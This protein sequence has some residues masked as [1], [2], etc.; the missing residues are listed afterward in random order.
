MSS[1][2][3]KR[4]QKLGSSRR[5]KNRNQE[6]EEKDNDDGYQDPGK[7]EPESECQFLTVSENQS[8]N[9]SS[10]LHPD[11]PVVVCTSPSSSVLEFSPQPQSKEFNV[12]LGQA[13]ITSKKRKMGSTRKGNRNFKF[14]EISEDE[15]EHRVQLTECTSE[16]EGNSKNAEYQN[17]EAALQSK[18]MDISSSEPNQLHEAEFSQVLMHDQSNLNC[19]I[20]DTLE[21]TEVQSA[22][23]IYEHEHMTEFSQDLKHDRS[24]LN[25]MVKDTLEG[26]HAE[27]IIQDEVTGV[28]SASLI[29]EH[30]H[31]TEDDK[32]S[33]VIWENVNSKASTED[34]KTVEHCLEHKDTSLQLTE[35]TIYKSE[36]TEVREDTDEYKEVSAAWDRTDNDSY[37]GLTETNLNQTMVPY[38][39][40]ISH[41]KMKDQELGT[42]SEQILSDEFQFQGDSEI[43]CYREEKNDLSEARCWTGKSSADEKKGN[44]KNEVDMHYNEEKYRDTG[45]EGEVEHDDMQSAN[46]NQ[47]LISKVS[48]TNMLDSVTESE[49]ISAK[50]L[51]GATESNKT[52]N[53]QHN[54][55]KEFTTALEMQS[56]EGDCSDQMP[57]KV[58]EDRSEFSD[59]ET[60]VAGEENNDIKEEIKVIS[61]ESFKTED[62]KRV[63]DEKDGMSTFMNELEMASVITNIQDHAI[64]GQASIVI[65]DHGIESP[66][67]IST[68]PCLDSVELIHETQ[69][70]LDMPVYNPIPDQKQNMYDECQVYPSNA[71]Q[72]ESTFPVVY[73]QESIQVQDNSASENVSFSRSKK[74]KIDSFQRNLNG[75]N[76]GGDQNAMEETIQVQSLE[77]STPVS[78]DETLNFTA[79]TCYHQSPNM[80]EPEAKKIDEN[81]IKAEHLV[82]TEVLKMQR[83]TEVA[84]SIIRNEETTCGGDKHNQPISLEDPRQNTYPDLKLEQSKISE[85][86][87]I[88][89]DR[90]NTDHTV[91]FAEP[92]DTA[93]VEQLLE[94]KILQATP[95]PIPS[96]NSNS[97]KMGSIHRTLREKKNE[98]DKEEDMYVEEKDTAFTKRSTLLGPDTAAS[99]EK[100]NDRKKEINA[101]HREKCTTEAEYT[102]QYMYSEISSQTVLSYQTTIKHS[103]SLTEHTDFQKDDKNSIENLES[104]NAEIQPQPQTRKK[105]K[106]GSTRRPSGR[107]QPPPEG[108]EGEWKELENA[109]EIEHQLITQDAA[110]SLINEP[111]NT[112]SEVTP[113]IHDSTV[114]TEQIEII[115]TDVETGTGGID[116]PPAI[117]SI[118]VDQINT[119][120]SHEVGTAGG[121]DAPPGIQVISDMQMNTENIHTIV[122]DQDQNITQEQLENL[123]NWES[124]QDQPESTNPLLQGQESQLSQVEVIKEN[125]NT[126]EQ[127]MDQ[128]STNAGV[129]K[130]HNNDTKEE[131][132]AG[133]TE[134]FTE[135]DITS[136]CS[137]QYVLCELTS[138]T[139][140]LGLATI[141]YPSPATEHLDFKED[142]ANSIENVESRNAEI[143]PQT[144]TRKKKKIGST[145]RP[146][147]R[148]QPPPEGE[149]GEWKELENA[150]EI[151]H[152]L[153]TQDATSNLI[154]EP[155]NTMS[156]VTPNIH[157]S[158]V[159]TEQIEI[160]TTDVETGTGGIDAQPSIL[161]VVVDQI[162]TVASH[163]VGNA[164]V[165]TDTI[166]QKEKSAVHEVKDSV[167]MHLDEQ[168]MAPVLTK[169][170]DDALIEHVSLTVRMHDNEIPDNE[171][172]SRANVHSTC[173]NVDNSNAEIKT[174]SQPK[175]KKKIGSTRRPRGRHQPPPEGEEGEWKELEN[176]EE[177]EHQLITQDATSNL[178]NEPQNTMSEVT[179]NIHDSTETTEQIEMITT[180]VETGTGGI[181]A[182][183]AILSIEVDQI[184][185]VVSHEVGTA[186]GIDAPPGIQVI[187]DMQMNTENIHTSVPDQ[188]QNITQEQLENLTNWKSEQDQPESTNPLLQGQESQLSQVE[189]I[190]ENENTQ[191]Q[192]KDQDSTN[193]GVIKAHNNDTK[194]EIKA[195]P[196]DHFTK[197][198][199]TS[200]CSQQY[201]LCELTSQT[202]DLGLATI[203]YPS[204]ATEHLD[205]TEDEANSIENVESR[206]AEIQPQTQTR[207]KKKIGSTRRPRGRHQPPP[208]GEEGE[209]KELEN[210]EEIEHQLITQDAASSLINEPQNTMSE[211]T[212][213]IHDST[214]TTE[215]I[216][217]I[218]TDVETGTG[219]IDAQPS[220]L[221]VE[222]DQIN[223]VASREV[224]NAEVLTDTIEQKEKSAVHEVKD[225]VVMHLNEQEMAPVVTKIQDDA[226]IEHVSLTVRMHDNEILDNEC[227]SRAN[228]HSTCEN[229]DNSNAEIETQSQTKTKKKIGSTRRPRG[230][231]QPPPE[232][233]E[234]EW[235]DLENAE[236]IEHQLITQVAASSLINEPQNTMSEVT[237]NIHDS[238]VTTEQIEIITTDVETGTGGID[239]PP[240]ILSIEV[241]QI[242]TVVSHEVATA[243]GIDAPPGIQVI[244]DMQM[245]TENIRTI[246]PDQDQNITQEQLENLTN[247]ESEQDQPESTNPLLQGQESQLSQ[248][249]VIKENENTQ[250]QKMDQDSTNAGVIKA[251]NNDTKE[252]IKAG[253][254]E[255]FTEEDITSAC[256]QQYVLCELTSQTSDLGLATI[257]YP[258]PATEHLDFKEDEANS[259]ENVKSRNAEIQPQTQ[260]RKKKKI[261][262]TRRPRGRHQPPPEGEEGEWKELENAEEIEHQLITQDATSNLINEP[263]NTMSEVTP[264][265]HDS[266]VTTEQIEIISTDV[267]TGTGGIDAQPSI[268]SVE[269]DQINT[270]ASH[271]VGNAEVLTDTIEQKEKSA[272]HEVKDS[273]VMHLDEQE[274][275]PVV[276]KIQDDALIEHVSLTVR[277]HD[278]EIPDNECTS[279]ANV[280]STCEN[281]DN[282][283]AEIETQSQ[284]KTKKKIGSTRRPRGRHQPPPEGEEGEWKDLENAEEIEHQLIT[285]VAASSLINEPQNTMSE[286]TPN[287]HDSTETTEQIEMITT[288][289][290]TGTGGIDAPPAILSIEVDQ[291]NTVVSHEVGTAG[292]IDAPP[293]IQVISDMQMNTENIHTSVPDQDQNITQ[294]QLENLTNWES[295]QDQ[296]ENT[297]PLL[298]GQESQLF[299]VEVIKENENTQEQKMDQDSTNAGVIKAH[300]NDTKEEIKA[301]PTEHFT[302]EDITSACSQQYV[303]CELTSQTSDLG[304]ATIEYPSPATE[305]PDFKEDEA[306]SIK[307]VESR[308]AEIQPQTQT[309]KKKK[310]GSTRRPRGRHQPPPE[311]EEGEWKELENAEEIEH[312]LITQDAASSLIN[313][314]QNTMSEVTPN[315]H[316]STVTTEQIEIISTDV[317]TGTGGID[318]Q[319]SILSV[320]VDQINTVASHEVGNA[321]VLT[322]TIEQK[323]K[324]AVHEVKDSVVMH[325]D[326]QEMAPVLTKI[327]DDVLIEHVS[328]TVR[329]H[330]NEILDNECA[331]RANVHSTCE[332]VDN[333]NAEIET[334]SQPKTKKKIGSTRRPRGRHQPPPEGEEGEWKD[335]ENAEE[336]EHQLITQVAAS[337]LINEPQNTMSEVTP[338][339]HDSTETT[340]QIEMITTDVETGTGGIDAPPAILSIE[341]DQINTVV[342]HE[343]GTA[344]GIDAPP[345]TQVISDMQMNTENIHTI[346]PDQDQNITQEQLENLTNWESE[347]DQPESTNPLLQGQE[348]Q[349]FQV[350]VI[351]ENENTQEQKM[352]QDSTNAGVIE[353]HNNDT[354]EEII[355]GPTEHFT[356]EDITSACS[357]QYVL[358]ELTSQTSDLGLATIEYPS[359]ATEHPDFKEDEANSIE[360]V[361]SR[362]AEIQPQTQTRKKKKIGSTR[363]P[364]GRHQPPPEGDEGE[365]KELENAEEIEHQLITQDAASSLINEPQNTM[366]EVTPNIHD[367]TV[368]TEQIEIITTDVETGTGGI[369]APPSILSVEVDQI[370]T[371]ASHEVGNAE[372]LTDTIE[373]KEK[374]AVHEV[375]DS[376]LMHLDEQEMAPVVTKIQDDALIEHV[377]LTV[378]MHD[379]EIPDNECASRANVH[380][381]CENVDNSNAEIKTQSQPKAKKKI[382]ST[383]RPRGRHQPPPEGEEGEWKDLENAEEIEHQLITQVAASSL[384][385]EPQ[386]TMSE[387]TP[388][389]HDSTETTEQIEMITTDVETGTGGIDAPPAILSIEV[390][391][392]NTVVSHEVGT[393]GGIDAPPGI[394]VI[395]DMQMNTENIHT[396]VPDQ[397][398]NITQEQLENLTNWESEQDQPES[399]N[400]LLQ[401]QESQLSQVEVIKENEN[402]Q[403]QKM[404]QDSTNAGV[405]KAHNNDTKEDIKTG[406]TE[407]FTEEDITSACSQQY[408][409]CELTSQTSD[410]GL[411][412]IEY[413]S[414]AT[415]HPDFKEDEANSI[416]NVESRNVEIQPQTQ[417][418][419]K[420]KIGS[421]RRPRGRHQPPPE[422]EEGEWKEL[423]NAEEI[424]HQL[425][426][427]VAASS[428]INE[429]QNTMSEVT[430]NIHDSTVTTEQIEI[431]TTEGQTGTGGIDAQ[432]SILSVE[433]D[434]INTVASH[435]VG[436]AEGLTDTI[437]QK[438]KSAVHEVKDSVVMHLDEQEMAPVVTKIQDD[439]LIEH[440]SL[441]VRMHDNEIPDNE[442]ASRANVHSTCENVESR[443]AEIQPQTQTRKKKKIGST[444]R[445]RGRHQPPPE[446]EEGEWKEL[447]N[448]EEIEHQLITQDAA[449]SLINEPQNTMSEVTPNI[450]DSTVTTEQIEIITTD[451]ETGTGGIDAQPSILSVEVDQINTVASHEVG[452]AEGLTDTI[453]QKEKSAVHEVKDS[454]LMHLD[455]QEMAPVVTKIQ[456]DAL[457]EHVSL[458]VRMHDNEIPDNECA[459]IANVHSTCENMD[460]SNAGIQTQRQHN[461]KKKF[462]STRRP[463]GGHQPP[464]DGEEEEWKDLENTEE[465][466][467]IDHAA[468]SNLL[469][470]LQNAISESLDTHC[471][472]N[473]NASQ[474]AYPI[475]LIPETQASLDMPVVSEQYH[476]MFEEPLENPKNNE[477]EKEQCDSTCPIVHMQELNL[478]P[479]YMAKQSSGDSNSGRRKKIGSTRRS[480]R[481]IK[482]KENIQEET[483]GESTPNSAKDNGQKGAYHLTAE[484]SLQSIQTHSDPINI[485]EHEAVEMGSICKNLEEGQ[486]KQEAWQ[487]S[488]D[489]SPRH[490]GDYDKKY[491]KLVSNEDI[492]NP[493]SSSCDK[494]ASIQEYKTKIHHK[495]DQ[496]EGSLLSEIELYL[497]KSFENTLYA[498]ALNPNISEFSEPMFEGSLQPPSSQNPQIHMEQSSPARKR[499]MGS[500]RKM[501]RNKHEEKTPYESEGSEQEKENLDKNSV[502]NSEPKIEAKSVE[503]TEG[504]EDMK[505]SAELMS[506]VQALSEINES[507]TQVTEQ[508]LPEGRRKF[509]SRRTTKG[510]SGLGAFTHGDYES[511][512]ENTDIQ[513]TKDLRVS[514]PISHQVSEARPGTEEVTKVKD[515]NISPEAGLVS[516]DSN[517]KT[518]PSVVSTGIRQK[519]DFEQWNEQNFGQLVYNIVMVGNS[520]VGKTSFI[521]RLQSGHFIPD[522]S[523]TIGVDTFV[524]T[525]TLGSKT[526]KLY[527]WD[528]AGQE[529]YH[530][531]TRQ[532]FHKA[533]GLLLMYDITSSQSF[534]AVRAWISQIQENAHP[535]VILM[536]LGNK[537]DCAD[538]EVQLQEGETLSKEYDI[539]FME[540]S[541]ATGEN[542]SESLKT[543]AW[544]LMKQRVRKEEEHKTLQPKPQQNKKS[545]CC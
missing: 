7:E 242:N 122:P 515:T 313:E 448:A 105:K 70:K 240:A 148:H 509:G 182:P 394:Q 9:E 221:S 286:V 328:L 389:I 502:K 113:N 424:E 506:E 175:T 5:N 171:C 183:P 257:E 37:E 256:S 354:K 197:E 518:S 302:E 223:T 287:I 524:H 15:P 279:R 64:T 452:N 482:E 163:E 233:E 184:N 145:R 133:P 378:R 231:H 303:L 24:S 304:L 464:P 255:H 217:I 164:E 180:D 8:S 204:P 157:D 525:V 372:V 14:E 172:A 249:E 407:H 207:K 300:N 22:S 447:E 106:I 115:T 38:T 479:D 404:D 1:R 540:C 458:T 57:E 132:K 374:S 40:I 474:L 535:D 425:I 146:R 517:R 210:A 323:E 140:D 29:Y 492:V 3:S 508:P 16:N 497:N 428:L 429:P 270:V 382:G 462:G 370:N 537:N 308:N 266:T 72:F 232:G 218:T 520:S 137:Q 488:T 227:A 206:N 68:C 90:I 332:N 456:D 84:E 185:T 335:L 412:T 65:E 76:S 528:T 27:N 504:T 305:H 50:T 294:E 43:K 496:S 35:E 293:G 237:P 325:L 150:E 522:Y 44:A 343:V 94:E 91:T 281:V 216:E 345:G 399:T 51:Y 297:N 301:G 521:K 432:P 189:V 356:E 280:H 471:T 333:S 358:C 213:N 307:N 95:T 418:R 295:E 388:N 201:V 414:P 420:K 123:T 193:A 446:G 397:D 390:D 89:T 289:V 477:S 202:S 31:M 41:L 386:N 423:E 453:E 114:T 135:E 545:G 109:E 317:E 512:Q 128:D 96:S 165:L 318:A 13:D 205:F 445:P 73:I 329:M 405:I 493:E 265:I 296:P 107:H 526:V 298:Q 322:D 190:K 507:S 272:V 465:I 543:L 25:V 59:I 415:E 32:M 69:V 367:S 111:Q 338:N 536:L 134:H 469:T 454:V 470:E 542:V 258:S 264:N 316:D 154:N 176:A 485:I 373:Q 500:S 437:E 85:C 261:G 30:E 151:E 147:G 368:T 269:V 417:T 440:V 306:N 99:E 468:S 12:V 438:E 455:E 108:E 116:A 55:P 130:A 142:E 461:K 533:Q 355:A 514:D 387:V 20:N 155:Q 416:K 228:A 475:Q 352:D 312:Q 186:G 200:A 490:V 430:P 17:L 244:S 480:L 159:T 153:I 419:K 348:S 49:L 315:I 442:C 211:V 487:R 342:S 222:V 406:P 208:E 252:E 326:E 179:P 254:T 426:T 83:R 4:G 246:V 239:A 47:L 384:I 489:M 173:E 486:S 192:K 337:S 102:Q 403:E 336:I 156:E 413:P 436:N 152:Q 377:S 238:T 195:G 219:G 87:E 121:I 268:L 421:T 71:E 349:L 23:L 46:S 483:R 92:I 290:E 18:H 410:L 97:R 351:K 449:S 283:N 117:L 532:V 285:Q 53:L 411:A 139:S 344:G 235:K 126:Q 366:S 48:F 444:R 527:V 120:V 321:E 393:A 78:E 466:Q 292:G 225:S 26:S 2:K 379:N 284:P 178:I 409:L 141:E 11:H 100:D 54:N 52:C 60:E 519:I 170:Q 144:Q 250:E 422:G 271:E 262:S 63:D 21:V 158:T 129:I 143:Q 431:I 346:V 392:I 181:D 209:W 288:D 510:C 253:P 236:E 334:Q 381:T 473:L 350:E 282:N 136:A 402:T 311:G 319:P 194:E 263:Q 516:L 104:K 33:T 245:N 538:R 408:V 191:E 320:E 267:E 149:E 327:Q 544:L 503:E 177:I 433:V 360:N 494:K 339:I 251:H 224:A 359:P 310:I 523:S 214:V 529:R 162:N 478:A 361:E 331:S 376:V 248:V 247:W 375:K 541:V 330:D 324:S 88:V 347:Q 82:D 363:R 127:K 309:R 174:Q 365:W 459:S 383:R 58:D 119:V 215:Q 460:N 19:I 10:L 481:V 220:I 229:V 101:G 340:E 28:Q 275:A 198:D 530:S 6:T 199:I 241:D 79:E 450:H 77:E 443:N 362:N 212:P 505:E 398:Q 160:I 476:T 45:T 196:T 112:M 81:V 161:S 56:K 395:S 93:E 110:S 401:G 166:E 98:K 463:R 273:V 451:V 369:D 439:A 434:Q 168:E 124:E 457:I 260:T 80:I 534:H 66:D 364:R 243:G 138:Q 230:R 353:A 203:E 380:S 513:M 441:T 314:P 36:S 274:M 299:Q 34:E 259:I 167:V 511:N 188:D 396:S 278:N 39:N 74:N 277:M 131:I 42:S 501:P 86:T 371:V 234:G 291:I 357:Q 498:T 499:K 62:F 67:K 276:T 169:I 103:S 495:L 75:Q 385:N 341:V 391:Q 472:K 435:E 400:P 427:Q 226:L 484:I 467:C 61:T 187:S 118:E 531:I 539:H 125:E 491:L